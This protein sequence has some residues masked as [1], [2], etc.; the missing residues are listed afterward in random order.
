[1]LASLLTGVAAGTVLCVMLIWSILRPE[2]RIWPP[3]RYTRGFSALVWALTLAVFGAAGLLGL[4][5]WGGNGYPA[6]LRHGIGLPLFVLANLV[7]WPAAAGFGYDQTSGAR[8]TLHTRGLY[9]WSRNPQYVADAAMLLG[10]ALWSGALAVLPVAGIGIMA[11]L[12]APLAEEPWL[13][14]QYG[15]AWRRYRARV[16]RYL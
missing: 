3:R 13:E 6:W 15:D 7:V 2:R 10:W 14:Q 16:R 9:A 1:M 12:L 8:G 5:G 11:L 4:M